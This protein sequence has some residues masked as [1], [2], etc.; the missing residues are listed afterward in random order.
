MFACAASAE[1]DLSSTDASE[2]RFI[3]DWTQCGKAFSHP[4]NLRVHYRRHTDEKP[5]HCHH[6]EAAYRQK[7][8]LKYHLEKVHGEKAAGRCSR[9]R[10]LE[11]NGPQI[12][13]SGAFVSSR[14]GELRSEVE[15]RSGQAVLADRETLDSINVKHTALSEVREI[16]I[17]LSDLPRPYPDTDGT[18]KGHRLSLPDSLSEDCDDNLENIDINDEWLLD[19]DDGFISS[20]R[21]PSETGVTRNVEEGDHEHAGSTSD[22]EPLDED[23]CEE[24]RKLSD[25]I[26]SEVLSP[27]GLDGM[28][29][30]FDSPVGTAYGTAKSNF[31]VNVPPGMSSSHPGLYPGIGNPEKQGGVFDHFPS[32]SLPQDPSVNSDFYPRHP[33]VTVPA[34]STSNMLIRGPCNSDTSDH[35]EMVNGYLPDQCGCPDI[36]PAHF[37]RN[38][39][40]TSQ[41]TR[42]PVDGSEVI[43]AA[44]YH[45]APFEDSAHPWP[46]PGSTSKWSSHSN[47]P[48]FMPAHG[49]SS[50][51]ACSC[52]LYTSPSPRDRTRS[53]MPSSA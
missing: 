37:D 44:S 38:P 27:R 51:S 4:D 34:V 53:R 30:P 45:S 20:R 22:T 24:L 6:C 10:K 26:N 19:E 32:S 11:N 2:R 17:D 47:H 50:I 13:S 36:S 46:V 25:A 3:C 5:H 1:S 42:L 41:S 40:S 33:E 35:A 21:K 18:A 14:T 16:N 23:L 48:A 15:S 7:S 49:V 52:L 12:P 39:P 8:G 31:A 28:S 29:S 43:D 9:K